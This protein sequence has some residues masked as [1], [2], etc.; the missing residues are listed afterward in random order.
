MQHA[1][2]LTIPRTLAE[3]CHPQRMA[4]LVYD[5]QI[6]IL[7][8]IRNGDEI[9]ARVGQVVAAARRA[10]LRVVFMRH[11]SLPRELMG[12]AQLR[13]AMT[14]QRTESVADIQP[15]FL[16]AS[17]G[18]QLTPELQPLPSEAIFDKISMS[19]FEGTPLNMVLRDCGIN[20]FAIVG[21][22]LEIGIDPTVRHAADLGYI[23]VIVT[24]AC[25]S[26]HEEAARQSLA[27]LEYAG[28]ALLTDVAG[29]CQVLDALP[30]QTDAAGTEQRDLSSG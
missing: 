22:A 29:F 10:G 2:G 6:G 4:L 13:M 26:G 5:M 3:V 8:Q 7:R 24:D 30:P 16:P 18:F 19:A 23:P 1:F 17:P 25:G 11:M 15:W 20:A 14:W 28:D 12:V 21:V 27:S 9:T